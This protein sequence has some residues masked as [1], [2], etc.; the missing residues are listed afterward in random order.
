VSIFHVKDGLS[1]QRL[2]NGQIRIGNCQNVMAHYTEADTS[3][4]K[5][6]VSLARQV[7]DGSVE[8]AP[9]VWVWSVIVDA[10]GLASAIA[11]VSVQGENYERWEQ[12]RHFLTDPPA[13][14]GG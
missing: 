5:T 14:T 2:E 13:G 10:D 8:Y 6:R 3:S 1:F 7:S 12:L 9:H 11:S 4:S